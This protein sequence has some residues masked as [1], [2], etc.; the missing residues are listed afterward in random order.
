MSISSNLPIAA[1]QC[2]SMTAILGEVDNTMPISRIGL[3]Q[4]PLHLN[5]TDTSISMETKVFLGDIAADG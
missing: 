5:H 2:E 1:D 4:G 3:I